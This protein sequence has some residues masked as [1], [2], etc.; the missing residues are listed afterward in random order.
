MF[1]LDVTCVLHLFQNK[2]KPLSVFFCKPITFSLFRPE[3]FYAP[4]V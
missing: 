3:M 1:G 4:S 2:D